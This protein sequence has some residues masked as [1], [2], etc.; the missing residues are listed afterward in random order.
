[1]RLIY[2]QK[3]VLLFLEEV[4]RSFFFRSSSRSTLLWPLTSTTELSVNVETETW[5]RM[6]YFQMGVRCDEPVFPVPDRP[7]DGS[8]HLILWQIWETDASCF[9]A[10]NISRRSYA[11]SQV[12]SSTLLLF[13]TD[14]S[15]LVNDETIPLLLGRCPYL[16]NTV[17]WFFSFRYFTWLEYCSS[18]TRWTSY[19]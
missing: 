3:L 12:S 16:L 2:V 6:S 15:S 18:P 9:R 13:L 4:R 10:P 14:R 8:I 11:V 1:M 19:V 17:Y 5:K 7:V